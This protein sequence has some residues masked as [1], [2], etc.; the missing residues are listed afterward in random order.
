M[1][2]AI[3][4]DAWFP[5]VNGVVRTLSATVCELDRLGHEVE[6]I[7]PQRFLTVPMPGYSSIRLAMAPR[8]GVRRMLDAYQPDVVH[9]STEGPIGWSARGWCLSRGV[10]F[11]TAFH[12]RFPR[13]CRR[14]APASVPSGSGRSCSASTRPAAP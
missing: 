12:T 4:T 13:I 3:A 6:L 8:F 9:I 2:L 5:Q 11:T 7:T 14:S 1:R 10:P